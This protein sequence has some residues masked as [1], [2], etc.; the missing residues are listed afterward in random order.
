MTKKIWHLFI[1][2]FVISPSLYSQSLVNSLHNLSSSGPGSIRAASE[3]EVC[4][5][6]HTPHSAKP[7][8]PLWNKNDPGVFYNLYTSSTIQAAPN[9]PT[10]SSILCLSCHD[11]TIALGNVLSRASDID[12]SGGIT[13]MP[14]GSSNLSTDL[15]DDHPV[16][17]QYNSALA[18]ADGQ[19]IDPTLI[20]PPVSMQNGSLECTSCHDPHSDILGNFLVLSNQFSELCYKCHDRNY[21]S[22]SSHNTSTAIWNGSGNNPWFHTEYT[23][24][25]ENACENCH[26]PHG[27]GG[28]PVLLNYIAEENN[29]LVCHNSNVAATDISSQ[30]TKTYTH[31]VYDYNMTHLPSENPLV[32]SMHVECEDCH[33][34]HAANSSTASAP[35]VSGSIFGAKGVDIS[36]GELNQALNQ[37]EVCFR[38]HADSPGKPGS[39]TVRV[40]EQNNT[41]LEFDPLNPSYHPIAAPGKNTDSPSLILPYSESS[42]IYC[43]DCH[44]SDGAGSPAGPHGSSYPHILKLRYETADETVETPDTYAL[45]YSC[46][47]R[48]SIL[49]NESFPYHYTHI[50]EENAPCNT[51]HDPHGIN[52]AQGTATNNSHL[53]NFDA[54]IVTASGSGI[55]FVDTGD[56]HGYCMLKCHLRGH[57]VGMSY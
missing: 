25:D 48:T 53:I 45:C 36:G 21:W 8:S 56:N 28:K 38:C 23:R 6:C 19:L 32:T 35:A 15:S 47:S 13:M 30:L 1:F 42:M 34:P 24:V 51:C 2:L 12:F 17:F 54:S 49:T 40:I 46:H 37:Y 31:N 4:I 29:C 27:A 57:G 10:N 18:A 41:R 11:G 26:N 5:F 22:S 33:N 43:S 16:S 9:Q 50:V 3:Q 7:D 20:S 39:A 55:R 52:N 44:A 14:P